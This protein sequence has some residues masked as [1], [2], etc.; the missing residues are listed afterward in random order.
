MKRDARERTQRSTG[1]VL[2][3]AAKIIE[4]EAEIIRAS[5]EVLWP[6]DARVGKFDSDADGRQRQREYNHYIRTAKLLRA[7]AKLQP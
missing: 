5:Y 3:D 7:K 2:L 4:T 1:K 6:D